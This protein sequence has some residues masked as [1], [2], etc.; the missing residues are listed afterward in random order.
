MEA[1]DDPF[2]CMEEILQRHNL[3]K[4]VH[5]I[6]VDLHGEASSEK[7]A[8]AHACDGRVSAVVGSHTHTPTAD[9][10]ILDG[11]T[12]FTSDAGMCGDYNSVIGMNKEFFIYKFKRRMSPPERVTPSEGPGTLCGVFIEIDDQSGLAMRIEPVRIGPRLHQ[13]IPL[14]D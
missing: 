12:A 7:M 1:L 5:A 2:Q 10:M 11:G 4:T 8:F 3:G 14:V 13:Y 9:Q 6:I